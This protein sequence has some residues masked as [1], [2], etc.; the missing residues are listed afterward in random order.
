MN[1]RV[2]DGPPEQHTEVEFPWNLQARLS[3]ARSV[4][5]EEPSRPIFGD[6]WPR[7]PQRE[8]R[9][10]KR[11]MENMEIPEPQSQEKILSLARDS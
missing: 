5:K 7:L 6:S 8:P 2:I 4:E 11:K 10:K 9:N 1:R 3:Q